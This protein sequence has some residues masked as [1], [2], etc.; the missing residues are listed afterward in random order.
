[1]LIL[2]FGKMRAEYL[3][4]IEAWKALRAL[5]K[6]RARVVDGPAAAGVVRIPAA[7]A[8][9]IPSIV[10]LREMLASWSATAGGARQC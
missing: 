10:V 3:M 7:P 4:R 6:E 5:E 1:M 2:D 9:G 8:V